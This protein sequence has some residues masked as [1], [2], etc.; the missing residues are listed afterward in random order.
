MLKNYLITTLRNALRQKTHT[1]TNI[2]GLT[3]GLTSA[4]FIFIW[5]KDEIEFDRHFEDGERIFN[6]M[7]NQA[8]AENRIY[9]FADTP[10]PLAPALQEEIPEIEHACR[11]DWGSTRSF[12]YEDKILNEEG[13]YAD[14]SFFYIFKIPILYGDVA[15]PLP[16]RSSVAISRTLAEKYF[17]TA[18][19]AIG[20]VFRIDNKYD[21]KVSSVYA[22]I[23]ENSSLHIDFII[24]FPLYLDENRWATYWYNNGIRTYLKLYDEKKAGA[25][26]EKIAD[27][28]KKRHE[29]SVVT[30]FLH[31]FENDHLYGRFVDGKPAG[32]RI[33]IIKLLG[34]V[35]MFIL[36]IA[37]INFM[38]L[39]TARALNRLKEVG[40]RKVLGARRRTLV[41][42]FTFESVLLSLI[43]MI[44]A[45]V[46]VYLLMPAFNVLTSKNISIPLS[47]PYFI[48]TILGITLFTGLLAGSYPS[49]LLSSF[50]AVNALRRNTGSLLRGDKL[51]K[52]LVVFQFSLSVILVLCTLTIF[53]QIN[54]IRNKDLGLNREQ[55]V[56]VELT[57]Q[58][59]NNRDAFRNELLR[60]QVINDVA[61]SEHNPLNV[62]SST[63]NVD[64]PGKDPESE[65]LIQ[66]MSVSHEFI[67]LM[68][69]TLL[70][71]RNFSHNNAADT[72][73]Y[74]VNEE[75]IKRTG[76]TN[77][78]GQDFTLWGIKGKI[79]GIIRNFHSANLHNPF[80]PLI[81]RLAPQDAF[82]TL[83]KLEAGKEKEG[84][85]YLDEMY[86]KW[87]PA[88]P[89]DYRFLDTQFEEM[90]KT[91]IVFGKLANSFTG[92]A[93]FISCLGLFGLA[94]FAAEKRTKEIGIRKVL[95]AN[96]RGL[97]A[98]LCGEF[99]KLVIIAMVIGSPI[100]WFMMQKLLEQ[101]AFHVDINMV[102]FVLAGG[103]LLLIALLTVIMQ[104]ATAAMSNP[105][106]VLKNE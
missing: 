34:I 6:V 32:G 51:R 28:V 4:I 50:Q 79:I 47:D 104:S 99:T 57:E 85:A 62:E 44:F 13:R 40:L 21:L 26:S 42:Q 64:W 98:M 94:T 24:P 55:V 96:V 65:V 48:A 9:T 81:L 91:D 83:I 38:N 105:A 70:E 66:I 53:A 30:L 61:F 27:F 39:A 102:N 14:S 72:A 33:R 77:P 103:G 78:L 59:R 10:G 89:F 67:P 49:L 41:L 100:A 56:M 19:D 43:S 17:N 92:I 11:T 22:D 90:Y 82:V 7:E 36:V 29:E 45:L 84:L 16:D 75:V 106:E 73:N 86:R 37:C 8:Y 80:E 68:G 60:S 76:L 101:Y 52:A 3:V 25:V 87:E 97:I 31:S 18:A 54:Y 2:L 88:R 35:A 69:I 23:P 46:I 15:H 74:I 5:I 95:G 63:A 71:G 1:I 93:I 58:L 12:Q 20:K